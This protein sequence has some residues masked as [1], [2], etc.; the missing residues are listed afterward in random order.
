MNSFVGR[1]TER[2]H[3]LRLIAGH[4]LVTLTGPGGI[5][6]TRLALEVGRELAE[7]TSGGVW[8]VELAPIGDPVGVVAA[9]ALAVGARDTGGAAE[10]PLQRLLDRLADRSVIVLLDNCEH[11]LD[12]A[13]SVVTA[14]LTRCPGVRIIATSREPLTVS[15]EALLPVPPLVA[16]A[17]VRLFAERAEAVRPDFTVDDQTTGQVDDLCGRLD[18]LPLAIELAAARVR[19]LPVAQIATRLQDRFSLLTTG[20]RDADERHRTLRAAV[21]WS[22]DLLFEHE[23]AAFQQLAIF[24]D[25]FDLPAAEALCATADIAAGDAADVVEHLID[26]SLLIERDGRYRML[27][28]LREFALELLEQVRRHRTRR[29]GPRRLL[30]RPR[31]PAGAPAVHP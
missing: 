1:E 26:K 28:T 31:E 3:I 16:D 22:Y 23:K 30:P 29:G 2:A 11:V 18:R 14:V 4:R 20:P 17:A 13:A 21:K 27:A 9:V 24:P 6:K 19:A 10:P 15:G 25:T 12:A 8:L 7:V 5:G